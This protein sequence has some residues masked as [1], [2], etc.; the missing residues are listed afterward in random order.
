METTNQVRALARKILAARHQRLDP[1]PATMHVRIRRSPIVA[2][3]VPTDVGL[4]HQPSDFRTPHRG[5]ELARQL[6]W[7]VL[8][9]KLTRHQIALRTGLSYAVV[10]KFMAGTDIRL[11]TASKIASIVGFRVSTSGTD[12]AAG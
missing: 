10:H 6:R 4:P 1:A 9:S 2:E 3:K 5:G 7:A 8:Q 12:A 11:A